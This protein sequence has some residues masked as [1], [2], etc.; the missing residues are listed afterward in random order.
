MDTQR[1]QA[2]KQAIDRAGGP[3]A[4]ARQLSAYLGADIEVNR[5]AQWRRIGIPAEW[6]V[7]VEH[8]VGVP[9]EDLNPWL[10]TVNPEVIPKL[11]TRKML[12]ISA[13]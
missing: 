4:L 6:G 8:L 12:R 1:V 9:R 10:Y 7:I 11:S 5:V 13:G 3:S 2:A